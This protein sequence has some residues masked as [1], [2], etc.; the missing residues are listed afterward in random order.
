MDTMAK[1]KLATDRKRKKST[2]NSSQQHAGPKGTKTNKKSEVSEA[3]NKLVVAIKAMVDI[4][5]EEHLYSVMVYDGTLGKEELLGSDKEQALAR[6]NEL[7]AT[8]IT[9]TTTTTTEIACTMT[10]TTRGVPSGTNEQALTTAN[11]AAGEDITPAPPHATQEAT[12]P[13]NSIY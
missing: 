13:T 9:T 2:I 11:G 10:T 5:N 12:P 3:K 4:I 1:K 7:P 6:S 8:T